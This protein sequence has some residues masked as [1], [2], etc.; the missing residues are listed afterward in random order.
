MKLKRKDLDKR[1]SASIKK[2]EKYKL[3]SR[4]GIYYKKIGQ[5]FIYMHIGATGLENDIVRIRG[6]VKP[7]ITDDIFGKFLI[8][9]LIVMNLLD[10]EQT[11]HTKLTDLRLLQ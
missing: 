4:G 11:V 9:N 8:W 7:Y 1:I 10:Y 3:K 5:Y 2:I 6:Y